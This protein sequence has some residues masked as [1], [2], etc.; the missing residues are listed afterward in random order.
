MAGVAPSRG[1]M[2]QA[3]E[4]FDA[5]QFSAAITTLQEGLKQYPSYSG[6]RV[7][8]GEIYWTTGEI[9]LAQTELEQVIKAVPDNFAAHRRLAMIYRDSGDLAAAVRSCQVVLQV[10][11]TDQ[12]MRVLLEH[13]SPSSVKSAPVTSQVHQASSEATRPVISS[14]DTTDRMAG[15]P[16]QAQADPSRTASSRAESI[17]TETLAELYILQGH[18]EE[19]LAVYRRLAAKDPGNRRFLDRIEALENP[20]AAEQNPSEPLAVPASDRPAEGPVRT[21]ESPRISPAV[22]SEDVAA[23]KRRK[24][25]VR[26]LEG[27]LQVIRDRRRQ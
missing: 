2:I 20:V 11:P 9:R 25:Q 23:L 18:L 21:P 19:G 13:I 6:A 14:G 27:W 1:F 26:R 16:A 15:T 24:N 5:G 8:L 17:D 10:N 12:E 22:D 3:K 4:L 7:L